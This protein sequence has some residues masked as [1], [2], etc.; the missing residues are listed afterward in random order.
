MILTWRLPFTE[1]LEKEILLDGEAK[2]GDKR[3]YHHSV[4]AQIVNGKLGVHRHC[5]RLRPIPLC[6]CGYVFGLTKFK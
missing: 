4:A 2:L 1:N 6:L 5:N 3:R